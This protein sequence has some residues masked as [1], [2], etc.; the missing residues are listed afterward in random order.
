MGVVKDSLPPVSEDRELR[1]KNQAW[2]EEQKRT[3]E[4]K[5]VKKA[6][7]AKR[8]E[9]ADKNRR[10]AEK[11]GLPMLESP[12]TSVSEIEGGEEPHW[13]NKLADEEDEDEGILPAGGATEGL[14]G[15]RATGGRRSLRG[16]GPQGVGGP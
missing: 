11:A 10:E 12:E 15:S 16:R 6:R 5:K 9:T 2:N 3:K 1:A 7:K 8:R 13:L 4:E 14:G